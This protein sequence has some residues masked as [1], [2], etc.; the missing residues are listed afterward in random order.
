VSVSSLDLSKR[1][2]I[3]GRVTALR[4][5]RLTMM[6]ERVAAAIARP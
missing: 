4:I 5:A 3:I 2:K 6:P 1:D